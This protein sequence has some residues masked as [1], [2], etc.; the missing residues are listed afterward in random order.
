MVLGGKY[1][2]PIL[3]GFNDAQKTRITRSSVEELHSL[4]LWEKF[5]KWS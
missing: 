1:F 3:I 5:K 4:S 2:L